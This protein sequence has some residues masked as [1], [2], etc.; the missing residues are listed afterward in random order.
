M[1]L[2]AEEEMQRGLTISTAA[3]QTGILVIESL[4][5][6]GEVPVACSGSKQPP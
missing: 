4:M 6:A 1:G 5:V 3:A 2:S